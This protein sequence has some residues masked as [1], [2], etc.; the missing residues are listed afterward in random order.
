MY[1]LTLGRR[2]TVFSG[3]REDQCDLVSE[4]RELASLIPE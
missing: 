4:F 2:D 3:A 1:L